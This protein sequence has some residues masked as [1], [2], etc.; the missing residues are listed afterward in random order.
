MGVIKPAHANRFSTAIGSIRFIAETMSANHTHGPLP[1]L[2]V[3]G[4][5]G[6]I[7]GGRHLVY[8]ENTPLNNLLLSMLD[9][10]GV[11]TETLGDSTG[12]LAHLSD[13]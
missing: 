10:S 11:R 2:L 6:A 4:G 7:K 13:I 9:K 3:G 1:T 12:E 5:A 8:P